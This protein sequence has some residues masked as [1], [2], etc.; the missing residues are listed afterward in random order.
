[1]RNNMAKLFLDIY[2][3]TKSAK[4]RYSQF[5]DLHRTLV[6][7]SNKKPK[8]WKIKESELCSFCELEVESIDHLHDLLYH[9]LHIKIFWFRFTVE[10]WLKT[11]LI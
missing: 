1:M 3:T 6:T 7:T 9:C 5:Q 10:P 4:L 2:I 11:T 8:L